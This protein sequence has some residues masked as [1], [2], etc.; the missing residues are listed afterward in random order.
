[1]EWFPT[2]NMKSV[3]QVREEVPVILVRASPLGR[4]ELGGKGRAGES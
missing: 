1:M 4:A 3:T 2:S